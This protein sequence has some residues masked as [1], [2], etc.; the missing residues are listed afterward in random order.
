MIEQE[1]TIINKLGLHA[2]AAAKFVNVASKYQCQLSLKH[3]DQKVDG[4]SIMGLMML[5]ATQ[6]TT[7]KLVAQG[8]DANQAVEEIVHLIEDRF[9][10]EQ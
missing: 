5:A 2:R 4:K 10:E 7:I 6:G 8:V 3:N 9:G 1:V